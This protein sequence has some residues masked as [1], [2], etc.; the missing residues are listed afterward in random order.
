MLAILPKGAKD[1]SRG[2]AGSVKQILDFSFNPKAEKCHFCCSWDPLVHV[3]INGRSEDPRQYRRLQRDGGLQ[4]GSDSLCPFTPELV[5]LSTF[6][7]MKR[8]MVN[9]S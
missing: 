8:K 9:E 2:K 6:M 3:G 5:I 7:G 4:E 1:S